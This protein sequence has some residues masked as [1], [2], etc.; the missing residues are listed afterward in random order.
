MV[1]NNQQ[2]LRLAHPI[3]EPYPPC[4]RSTQDEPICRERD[5][6]PVGNIHTYTA[7]VVTI[8]R[9]SH[10]PPVGTIQ[11]EHG[12][13]GPV[14]SRNRP[15]HCISPRGRPPAYA[16]LASILRPAG[17]YCDSMPI[18]SSGRTPNP[19]LLLAYSPTRRLSLIHS[20]RSILDLIFSH[21]FFLPHPPSSPPSNEKR[22]T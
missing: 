8:S 10:K 15:R 7:I 1:A 4:R 5:P 9:F 3:N 20:C 13:I 12:V 2:R 18:K 22:P 11:T 14:G 17:K 16:R 21:S 19:L 6:V